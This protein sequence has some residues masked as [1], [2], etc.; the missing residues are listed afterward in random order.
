[1]LLHDNAAELACCELEP[2]HTPGAIQPHGAV[3]AV[4]AESPH[5]V[6]HASANLAGVLGQAPD[7]VLGRPLN[8]AIGN[9]A[10]RAILGA[11]PR[12]G[13]CFGQVHS[14]SGPDEGILDLR[15][16]RTGRHICIDIELVLPGATQAPPVILTQSILETFRHAGTR[17]ELC[18]LAVDG[19]KAITG[20][21]RVMAYRFH[22]DGHG[23]VIAEARAADM[24]PY[25]GLHY[26]SGDV[27]P[28]ARRLYLRQSVGAIANACGAPSPL[29]IDPAFD[30]GAPLDLT[31]SVLRSASPIHREYMRNM[32]TAASLTIGLAEGQP[33]HGTRIETA[34]EERMLWGMLICHHRSPRICGPEIRAV[35]GM[36]G[37]VV[38]LLL[39]SLGGAEMYARRL[40]REETLHA[41]IARLG[42]PMPLPA[43]IA[44]AERH[45]LRLV[46]A[47]GA[48]VRL[49]GT[50]ALLGRTPP[51]PEA[52]QAMAIMRDLAAGE[53]LAIDDLGRR[54]PECAGPWKEGA[55]ALLLPL[56][57][58]AG[59][60]ILWFRPEQSRS[61]TWGGDPADHA[62]WDAAAGRL[63]PRASFA[64][65]K[66]TVSGLSAPWTGADL[67]LARALRTAIAAES[68]QRTKAAL[69]QLRYYDALTGLPN[70]SL[71]E[72]RLSEI[73]RS[74]ERNDTALLF[75][76]LDRFKAVNDTMGH[77]A[78]DALL[79]EVARRLTE[80]IGADQ[81]A[82]RLGGDE[83]VVLCQGLDAD[84]VAALGETIRSAIE[85]PFQIM[86][87]ACHI[88]VSIGIATSH[89][90]GGLDL[91]R[92]ADMAMYAAKQNGGN[93]RDRVRRRVIR[94]RGPEVRF[95]S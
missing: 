66:D 10:S 30:D 68:A 84:A 12:D 71:L 28:Q 37:Q 83:F 82:A 22:D 26:P 63:T 78:G 55:G 20:Y 36:I 9:A 67:D 32:G 46:D 14:M 62:V 80:A 90:A 7:A 92:A 52:E 42:D 54:N 38:S 40:A 1:M 89:L 59:D 24:E 3:L 6:T 64:A 15:A 39:A 74:A 41:L 21:D 13:S 70:R 73:A 11:T 91:V 31:H 48:M 86:G 27:P 72:D 69:A 87:R 23:E 88:S 65:W 33:H 85:A 35:A 58:D 95:R 44:A 49:G 93:R 16:H 8:E 47:D 2:I 75:L 5:V 76:D 94:A 43:A 60:A 61:V 57:M 25:L 79:I 81:L 34:P 17:A 4:L 56:T 53:V 50:S 77:A 45:L 19:L 18:T 29:L 51:A